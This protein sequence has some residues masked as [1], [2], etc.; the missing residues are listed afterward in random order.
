MH[1][2]L[3]QNVGKKA[4]GRAR[5]EEGHMNEQ[6]VISALNDLSH[7][8]PEE[9][10][11]A[12]HG[13]PDEDFIR[14]IDVVCGTRV[15]DVFIQVKSSRNGAKRFRKKH[16]KLTDEIILVVVN[17]SDGP[18]LKRNLRNQISEVIKN[19]LAQI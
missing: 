18:A 5:V 19:R 11:G 7:E 14:Q 17:G 16:P 13:S 12:R 8:F 1:V 9:F 10:K 2:S 15:G 3:F 6:R 4:W